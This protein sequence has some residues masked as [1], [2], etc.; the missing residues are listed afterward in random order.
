LK[1]LVLYA[2]ELPADV[3]TITI[4]IF[5]SLV[6]IHGFVRDLFKS[7]LHPRCCSVKSFVVRSLYVCMYV[8]PKIYT[9]RAFML[10]SDALRPQTNKWVF[11]AR[12]KRSV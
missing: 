4:I 6:E 9:Q 3:N 12:L 7:Y 8:C 10:I 5:H 11:R 2:L 1:Y